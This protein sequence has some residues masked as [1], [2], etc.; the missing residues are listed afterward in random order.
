ME[1]MDTFS[2]YDLQLD[3]SCKRNEN[4]YHQT[5]KELDKADHKLE[6]AQ[7][8]GKSIGIQDYLKN[9]KWDGT[10]FQ[11]DKSLKVIGAK[12]AG[13]QKSCDEKLKKILDDQN[14]IKN[15]LAALSK[16]ESKSF[17]I[18]DL[19]DLVYEEKI[20]SAWFVNTHGSKIMTTILVVVPKKHIE[21]FKETYPTVYL[22]HNKADYENWCRRTL[23]NI[24]HQNQN[25]EDE[26]Q[27][28]EIVDS[29]YQHAK[30]LHDKEIE[31][32]G[33]IPSSDKYLDKEDPDGNQLWRLTV[34]TD[35][36]HG[37][38]RVMKK[39]GF[40]CQEFTFDSDAYT[41]NK[42]LESKLKQELRSQNEKL[43]TKSY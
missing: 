20:S 41:A 21:R 25:I 22:S 32:P 11:I 31:L 33:V 13:I 2:K 14:D 17:M 23:A 12:V 38:I 30:K 10:K 40:M 36:A 5:A 28:K 18:K 39:Q 27:R 24:Q 6:I 37:Y 19:G 4:V 1:L 8:G 26:A 29:E 43:Y 7:R 15:K 42:N 9:F 3:A 35:H 16:K 34:M